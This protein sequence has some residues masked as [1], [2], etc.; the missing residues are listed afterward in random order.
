MT[1]FRSNYS[2]GPAALSAVFRDLQTT[3]NPAARM[4][5]PNSFYFL[6]AINWLATYKKESEM[7]GFFHTDDQTLREHI[8]EYVNAI[9]ALKGE[10]IVWDI[11]NREETFLISVDG[12]QFR[13]N[14][15]RTTPS[16]RWC[17]YKFKSAGLAYEIAIAIHDSKVVWIN[18][19]YQAADGDREI[20]VSKLKKKMPQGKK[21][22]VDRGYRGT[23]LGDQTLS[24]RNSLDTDAVKAFKRRVRAR[25]ENFNARVKA[26][27]IMDS[28]FRAKTDRMAK[29]K[30]A[31]EAVCVLC[32]YDM[33][34]GH[35]LFDV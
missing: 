34:N 2:C 9:A 21:A 17:S 29:H 19:P 33:E 1:R 23:E 14:E 20:Y 7:A 26:F 12:V 24:Y 5:K 31:F 3:N 18:G 27:K 32:Q 30:A 22:V 35:P 15:P 11:D 6:V 4:N 28:A 16:A 25:H 13:I 10:K 8:R